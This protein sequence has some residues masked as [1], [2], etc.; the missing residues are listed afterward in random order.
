[1][2]LM[3]LADVPMDRRD[4]EF[5]YSRLRAVTGAIILAAVAIA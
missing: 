4:H 1:M 5:H 3:R 2:Q